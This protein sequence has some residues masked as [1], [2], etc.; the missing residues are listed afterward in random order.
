MTTS[1]STIRAMNDLNHRNSDDINTPKPKI[2]TI[3]LKDHSL[4]SKP[5]SKDFKIN[6]HK[7]VSLFGI[8]LSHLTPSCQGLILTS[9]ILFGFILI[10]YVEEGFKFGFKDFSFGWFM[11]GIELIIFSIFAMIERLFKS[12]SK[13]TAAVYLSEQCIESETVSLIATDAPNTKKK[14]QN[15]DAPSS[16]TN[17]FLMLFRVN[18]L[19]IIFEKQMSI[20]YH[21]LV[22][23]GYLELHFHCFD[24]GSAVKQFITEPI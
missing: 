1:T 24:I 20:K 13:I 4:D 19:H 10:G 14:K 18:W 22:A 11:T 17:T 3:P 16:A 9:I 2:L 12:L 23:T 7:N 5:N 21:L 6:N 15:G 8:D